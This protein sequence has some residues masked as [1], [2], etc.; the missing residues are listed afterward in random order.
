MLAEAKSELM[1]QECKV[2]SLNTCIRELQRQ[3]HSQRLALDGAHCGYE[4]SRREQVRLQEELAVREKAPRDTRIRGI[5][6]MEELRSS[7]IGE[8][9]NSLHKKLRESHDTIQELTS[10]IQELKERVNCMNDSG[11]LQEV[12]SNHSGRLSY[13]S[14]QPA[15]I[16]GSR[17]MLSRDKRLPL[18][19]WNTSG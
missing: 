3:T 14:S 1:K 18:D 19:T 8:L 13:V 17:S 2:D 16:P 15:V 10:Q 5:H 9:K 7:R 11:E 12:E 4:E 6:E